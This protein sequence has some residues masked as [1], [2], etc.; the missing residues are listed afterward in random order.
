VNED[1]SVAWLLQNELAITPQASAAMAPNMMATVSMSMYSVII[2]ESQCHC[3]MFVLVFGG[4]IRNKKSSVRGALTAWVV[5]PA[6]APHMA[7]WTTTLPKL[8]HLT[9]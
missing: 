6:M 9:E 8:V 5:A 1:Q 4:F 2:Q 3:N 7:F